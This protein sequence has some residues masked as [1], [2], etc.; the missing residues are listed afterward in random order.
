[1]TP[2]I[3]AVIADDQ[4][5]VRQGFTVL[6]NAEPDI[7]V[8]GQAVNGLDAVAKV[9]ELTPDVVLMDIRMPELGGIEATRRITAREGSEVKVL[10]L[11]TFDLD[12]Y[13]YEALRAGASGFLLKD[14]SADELAHAVRVVATGDALLSPNITKRLI[15]EFSRTAGAPRAPLK[16]RIGDLTE[17]ETEVLSLIAAGLSNAEIAGQLTLAEQ[18]VKTHVGR[19]LVKLGVRDRTQ[20]AVF[21]YE[22]GLVR[23]AGL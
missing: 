7:E 12:E 8:V 11:T 2:P 1:M 17:R 3:R 10:V 20:A 18:T 9:D 16:E 13:V 21:A 14:A 6:L 4:M 23:P 15:V 5:M 19:I 22:S